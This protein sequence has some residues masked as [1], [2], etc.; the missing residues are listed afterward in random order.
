MF[1]LK[2]L[3]HVFKKYDSLNG[4]PISMRAFSILCFHDSK[5]FENE[6]RDEFL[7]IAKK[8]NR[9]LAEI[10]EQQ[11]LSQR[12]EQAFLGIFARP[13]LFELSGNCVIKT[14]KGELNLAAAGSCGI[15]IP[16]S[17]IK[18]IT[19]FNLTGIREITV[20]ENKTNYDE[21]LLSE[22]A[23]DELV[24]YHGGFLSPQKEK[25]YKK[26]ADA[27][28]SEVKLHFWADIDTGGF[29]MFER[30]SQ[31]FPQAVPMRM[32]AE[33]VE[34]Y[35]EQGLKRSD[36]YLAALKDKLEN[37]CFP[38]FTGAIEQIL[39]YKVTIEQEVFLA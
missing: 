38:L 21:Y 13:E 31:I 25:L 32:G 10:C 39:K 33:D 7:K 1:F 34:Y 36:D 5:V 14:V 20:I 4:E 26:L 2:K 16:S 35:H 18:E 37:N 15:A 8:Y 17:L 28:P 3:L 22:K 9:E 6:I 11:N 27:T 19:D 24:L 12:D 30:F 23:T 29:K